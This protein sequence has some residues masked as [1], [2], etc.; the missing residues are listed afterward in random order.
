MLRSLGYRGSVGTT[1]FR[2]PGGRDWEF[3]KYLRDLGIPQ[4]RTIILARRREGD[5]GHV[6]TSLQRELPAL[7]PS[8]V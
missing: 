5:H 4:Y 6:D 3:A 7:W 1:V 8:N 2:K